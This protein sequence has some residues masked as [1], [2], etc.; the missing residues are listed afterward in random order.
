MPVT[1]RRG[2]GVNNCANNANTNSNNNGNSNNQKETKSDDTLGGFSGYKEKY[3][4]LKTKLKSILYVSTFEIYQLGSC[5]Q[6]DDFKLTKSS[7]QFSSQQ[8]NRR[9]K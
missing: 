7:P 4:T 1:K 3:G 9:T 5:L 6:R 8:I 2:V